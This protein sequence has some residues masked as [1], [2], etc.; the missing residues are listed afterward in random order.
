M[1]E[2]VPR[3]AFATLCLL[4]SSHH[5]Q[6][7]FQAHAFCV[8]L[9]QITERSDSAVFATMTSSTRRMVCSRVALVNYDIIT[10]PIARAL[11]FAHGL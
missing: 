9:L 4:L 2:F 10:P 3:G 8:D 6:Y 11:G 7:P 1:A 5:T